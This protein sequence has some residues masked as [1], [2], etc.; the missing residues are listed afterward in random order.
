M[1]LVDARCLDPSQLAAAQAIYE[2]AFP[3]HERVPFTA[4][5]IDRV[6]VLVDDD[7]PCGL[8]VLRDLGDTGWTFLRYYCV[9]DRGCG[10]GSLMWGLLKEA[11]AGQTRIILDVENPDEPGT[12]AASKALRERRIAFYQRLGVRL[13]PVYDYLPPHDGVPFDLR[14][15]VADLDTPD[16]RTPPLAPADLRAVVLAVFE[17]RYGLP[18]DHPAVQRCLAASG[19]V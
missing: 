2:G 12:D 18:A 3:E 8:A 15:M 11:H 14:P 17:L 4:L 16:G 10:L 5:F 19:L 9:G 13:L 1:R 7:R 6:L